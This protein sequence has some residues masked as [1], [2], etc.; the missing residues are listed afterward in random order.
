MRVVI[1]KPGIYRL[2]Y[3]FI[4]LW[5]TAILAVS[6]SPGASVGSA[7]IGEYKLRLD[8]F[9]HAMAFIPL[10]LSAWI[11]WGCRRRIFEPAGFRVALVAFVL[12]AFVAESL[13]IYVPTRTF[14]PFDIVSNLSGVAAGLAI[15][16]VFARRAF[17][18]RFRS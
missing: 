16:V 6:I 3:T 12:L 13:Q 10:P 8:Y 1:T 18:D 4:L 14:N 11:A 5:S 15:A 7:V 17:I 2:A 9:F